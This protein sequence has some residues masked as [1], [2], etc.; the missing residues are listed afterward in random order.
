MKS[1]VHTRKGF[2]LIHWHADINRRM[3]DYYN[4][5]NPGPIRSN[6]CWGTI[7]NDL[8]HPHRNK[9]NFQAPNLSN[10]GF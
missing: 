2:L 10:L 4:Q 5:S 8:K 9:A 3:I 1:H 7:L 6:Q